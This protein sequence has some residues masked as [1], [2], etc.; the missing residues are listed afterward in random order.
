MSK[1]FSAFN[2]ATKREWTD[3]I[4]TDLK[5]ADYNEKLASNI[6]G[7]EISPIYH[8][9]DNIPIFNSSFP[10]HWECY[11]LINAKN[12]KEGNKRALEALQNDVSGLC[13]TNPNNLAVLLKDIEI[14]YIR[15]DFKDYDATFI[16]QWEEYSKGKKD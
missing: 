12:A 13:F 7:I 3:R 16:N 5:G 1:L 9:N 6:Q 8:A 14:E 4:T 10:K 11:Q 2:A 15:I